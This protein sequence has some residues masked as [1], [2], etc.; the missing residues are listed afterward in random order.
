MYLVWS[1]IHSRV[2]QL[3]V[4]TQVK[5]DKYRTYRFLASK[6]NVFPWM[7]HQEYNEIPAEHLFSFFTEVSVVAVGKDGRSY[8]V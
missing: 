3:L 7:T 2:R 1:V 5:K 6:L 4:D 8:C